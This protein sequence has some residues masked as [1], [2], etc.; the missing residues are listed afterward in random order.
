MENNGDESVEEVEV[1]P[2]ASS[3][4]KSQIGAEDV[5]STENSGGNYDYDGDDDDDDDDDQPF[6]ASGPV[7]TTASLTK[8]YPGSFA[9][10]SAAPA[11]A[12][13]DK[14]KQLVKKLDQYHDEV[15]SGVC[16]SSSAAL[17]VV[18]FW[19][20][21]LHT[22]MGDLAQFA[23]VVHSIPATSAGI[24]RIFSLAGIVQGNRRFRIA[25]ETTENE[26]M[27]KVNKDFY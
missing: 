21:K 9:K 20:I 7:E 5:V 16:S 24:E 26:L 15:S 23:L 2:L 22:H 8:K 27:I 1:P 19:H 6:S 17:D 4:P 11:P 13:V 12:E 18:G 25:A 3:S 14:E 10:K